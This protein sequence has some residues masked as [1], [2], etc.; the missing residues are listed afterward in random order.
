MA[1]TTGDKV[2][3][4]CGSTQLC[5]EIKGG[6]EGPFIDERNYLRVNVRVNATCSCWFDS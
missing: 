5:S 1:H 6:I 3:F 4:V 2:L